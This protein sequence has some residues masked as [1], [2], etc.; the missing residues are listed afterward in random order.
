MIVVANPQ[1]QAYLDTQGGSDRNDDEDECSYLDAD[2]N[3]V[4]GDKKEQDSRMSREIS[5]RSWNY[6][7]RIQR[8]LWLECSSSPAVRWIGGIAIGYSLATA[9]RGCSSGEIV[10]PTSLSWFIVSLLLLL[11]ALVVLACSYL[12]LSTSVW[13]DRQEDDS[14]IAK[15]KTLHPNSPIIDDVNDD[16][17][18]DEKDLV[19]DEPLVLSQDNEAPCWEE[20]LSGARLRACAALGSIGAP[21][22]LVSTPATTVSVQRTKGGNSSHYVRFVAEFV[23]EH[24]HLMEQMD[25]AMDCL[26]IGSSL[27]MGLGPFSRCVSRVE[28]GQSKRRKRVPLPHARAILYQTMIQQSHSLHSIYGHLMERTFEH[29]DEIKEN[30]YHHVLSECASWTVIED[31][32]IGSLERV[33]AQFL[34]LSFLASSRNQLGEMLSNTVSKLFESNLGQNIT[35]VRCIKDS[36]QWSKEGIVF[37]NAAFPT[38]HD[39]Q[40]DDQNATDLSIGKRSDPVDSR[41]EHIIGHMESL[42]GAAH[43]ALWAFQT[44]SNAPFT[45]KK[46]LVSGNR[47]GSESDVNKDEKLSWWQ[48]IHDMLQQATTIHTEYHVRFLQPPEADASSNKEGESM[49][50]ESQT[51]QNNCQSLQFEDNGQQAGTT[52]KDQRDQTSKTN[53]I[54]VFHGRGT[55]EDGPRRRRDAARDEYDE[56][57][58]P[59]SLLFQELKNRI[60]C[61]ELA[62]EMDACPPSHLDEDNDDE[63]QCVQKLHD[64]RRDT[65][66]QSSQSKSTP[67]FFGASGNLLLELKGALMDNSND[68]PEQLLEGTFET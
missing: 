4:M 56:N 16:D 20:A 46:G 23:E 18:A 44:T 63:I 17:G 40:K 32:S 55:L 12:L 52:M 36:I 50:V 37:L 1:L 15:K 64:V 43:I 62:E 67:L 34:T 39:T 60:D 68:I 58:I 21:S 51:E 3:S 54:L 35:V 53:K 30:N 22:L 66:A 45:E 61:L 59:T 29:T 31:E 7:Q 5:C 33:P 6:T 25:V 13:N 65:L 27:S 14:T 11:A 10:E 8:V 47:A 49:A 24:V 38:I 42:I 26:K 2:N 48:H 28:Q 9:S 57:A 41:E 19:N